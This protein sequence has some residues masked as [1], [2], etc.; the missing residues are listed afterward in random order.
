MRFKLKSA[1]PKIGEKRR[2]KKFAFFPTEVKSLTKHDD[3][4]YIIWLENYDQYEIYNMPHD[5]YNVEW[6]VVA[7]CIKTH[8]EK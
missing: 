1:S 5:S 4:T 2:I 8:E 7:K 6:N 3:Y